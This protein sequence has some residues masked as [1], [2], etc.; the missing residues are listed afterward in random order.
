MSEVMS[1]E[2][3]LDEVTTLIFERFGLKEKAAIAAVMKAQDDDFFSPHDDDPALRT[4][5]RAQ[6]DAKIVFQQYG[7]PPA[8][9]TAPKRK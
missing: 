7:K 9:P 8:P 1:Y 4:E 3:Y 6:Q 5:E 2:A